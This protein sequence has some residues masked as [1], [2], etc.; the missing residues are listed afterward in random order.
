VPIELPPIVLSIVDPPKIG[1][2][3]PSTDGGKIPFCESRLDY[4]NSILSFDGEVTS[5][6][7]LL[8]CR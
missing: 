7:V 6:T 5:Y 1:K 4:S 2:T 3:A 8:V